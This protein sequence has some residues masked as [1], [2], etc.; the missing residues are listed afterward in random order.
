MLVAH[1]GRRPT[2]ARPE[3]KPVPVRVD[4]PFAAL[5]SLRLI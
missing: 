2:R 3:P 5:A 1:G 4:S